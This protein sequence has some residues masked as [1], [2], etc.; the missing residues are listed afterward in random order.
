VVG[1]FQR[2]EPGTTVGLITLPPG[3]ILSAILSGG[4]TYKGQELRPAPDIYASVNLGHLKKLKAA[5]LMS[6]YAIY[7]HNE[8]QIM[9]AKNNPKRVAGIDDLVRDDIRTSMPNPVNEGIMQFYARRVLE[10]HGIWQKIA[11]GRECTACQT[12]PNNWFT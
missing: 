12:T 11:G 8:I 7:M 5:N 2:S 6:R 3:L 9:V 10:Q 1:E 4:W